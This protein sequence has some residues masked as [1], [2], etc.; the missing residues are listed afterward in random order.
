MGRAPTSRAPSRRRGAA[1]LPFGDLDLP[2]TCRRPRSRGAYFGGT[3]G[4]DLDRTGYTMIRSDPRRDIEPHGP[5]SAF[6]GRPTSSAPREERHAARALLVAHA[7]SGEHTSVRSW[8][9]RRIAAEREGAALRP[10]LLCG[11]LCDGRPFN[12][13]GDRPSSSSRARRARGSRGQPRSPVSMCARCLR[14]RRKA[15]LFRL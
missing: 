15:W 14:R 6:P 5:M 4:E 8:V 2:P 11:L 13:R 1:R 10:R 12:E 7:G 9:R 3:S